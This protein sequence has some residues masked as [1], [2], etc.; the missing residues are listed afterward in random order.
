MTNKH[1]E[2]RILSKLD[3]IQKLKELIEI[4]ESDIEN[5]KTDIEDN[6]NPDELQPL[7]SEDLKEGVV[8]VGIG[9]YGY[10]CRVVEEVVSTDESYIWKAFIA[11]DGCR[12][13]FNKMFTIKND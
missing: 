3:E 2:I 10:F 1:R 8:I 4:I 6:I 5:L 12:Y 11:D 9:D 13:G 7:K